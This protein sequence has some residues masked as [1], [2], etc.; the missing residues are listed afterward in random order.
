MHAEKNKTQ[1]ND[2]FDVETLQKLAENYYIQG[3]LDAATISY[4]KALEINPDLA[5]VHANIGNIFYKQGRIKEALFRYQEA[6]A[7]APYLAGTYWNIGLIYYQQGRVDLAS[8]CGQKALAL[9]PKWTDA[10]GLL[11]NFLRSQQKLEEKISSNLLLI[12]LNQNSVEIH[13][14]WGNGLTQQGKLDEATI[15][16]YQKANSVNSKLAETHD[17]IIALGEQGKHDEA[18]NKNYQ[19]DCVPKFDLAEGHRLV[20]ALGKQGKLDLAIETYQRL[21]DLCHQQ[22]RLEV[23]TDCMQ[24]AIALKP[25]WAEAYFYLGTLLENH[26]DLDQAIVRYQQAINLQ[27]AIQSQ[28]TLTVKPSL[29]EA[30]FRLGSVLSSQGKH[31]EAM[32]ISQRGI[33]VKALQKPTALN[34]GGGSHFF[35]LGWVNLEEVTSIFNPHPFHLSPECIFPVESASL[36]TVYTSHALEHIDNPTIFRVFSETYRVLNDNGRFV[37]K[38]PDFDRSL[39]YWRRRDESFFDYD[40]WNYGIFVPTW[41]NRQM[42]DCLDYRAACIFCCFWNDEYGDVYSGRVNLDSEGVYFGPPAMPAEF[43]QKLIAKCT[44]SEISNALRQIILKTEDNIHWGHQNAWSRKELEDLLRLTGFRVK[45]F[46]QE[47]ILAECADIPDIGFG[48]RDYSMYCWA[49]KDPT[50]MLCQQ[51]L[52]AKLIAGQQE[53]LEIIQEFTS[54]HADTN[55]NTGIFYP[56][57]IDEAFEK[58]VLVNLP[59]WAWSHYSFGNALLTQGLTEEAIQSYQQAISFMPG[60]AEAYFNLGNAFLQQGRRQEAIQSYQKMADINTELAEGHSRFMWDVWSQFVRSSKTASEKVD[61][62][63]VELG[64]KQGLLP[65]AEVKVFLKILEKCPTTPFSPSDFTQGYVYNPTLKPYEQEI[66]AWNTYYDLEPEQ[67][68]GLIPLLQKLQKQVTE[69]IGTPWLVVNTR[70]WKAHKATPETILNSWHN[71]GFHPAV[72]KIMVYLS[73]AST[74]IGTTE[75]SLK[76]G[77]TLPIIGPSGTWVLFKNTE[78]CHRGVAPKT[79]DRI[80]LEFTIAQAIEQDLRPVCAGENA[81]YPKLPWYSYEQLIQLGAVGSE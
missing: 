12:A 81:N 49:E 41:K 25:D 77:F 54:R 16:S 52:S 37:I 43:Y 62:E 51:Q 65:E 70:C 15:K 59:N 21:L 72:F 40:A 63:F 19:K 64:F 11:G 2:N 73:G 5:E 33:T 53:V 36:D 38:I 34:I 48:L 44:P 6:V 3:N 80:T 55:T 56:S 69:C 66:N 35:K 42:S 1:K 24:Q 78:I 76:D 29:I 60:C 8:A 9:E 75:L 13:Q 14:G 22:G 45:T 10:E 20:I 7:L 47:T 39:D 74:E 32:D 68:K 71:D 26:G 23:A 61:P 28:H 18:A 27:E 58:R 30:Y 46:D 79:Q 57:K 31:R 67:L 50:Y 4:L 17:R